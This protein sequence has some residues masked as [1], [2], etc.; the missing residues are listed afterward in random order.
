MEQAHLATHNESLKLKLKSYSTFGVSSIEMDDAK[1]KYT[2]LHVTC[3]S[4]VQPGLGML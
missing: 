1:T 4:G 2:G 3:L